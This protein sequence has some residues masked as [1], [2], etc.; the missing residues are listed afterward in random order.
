MAEPPDIRRKRLLFR[1]RHR[2]TKESD[3]LMGGFA[4]AHLP[5]MSEQ[6]LDS[7]ETLLNATDPEL[8]DW[9]A[10]RGTPPSDDAAHLINLLKNFKIRP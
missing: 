3:L 5:T 7:Y 1:S 9:L 2:G 8:F 6:Q 10:G 4:E